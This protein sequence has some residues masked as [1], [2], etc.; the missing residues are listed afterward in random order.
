MVCLLKSNLSLKPRSV[1]TVAVVLQVQKSK[2]RMLSLLDSGTVQVREIRK[3][4]SLNPSHPVEVS[5]RLAQLAP[6]ATTL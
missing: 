5:Q 6:L 3:R 1:G 4:C 2:T